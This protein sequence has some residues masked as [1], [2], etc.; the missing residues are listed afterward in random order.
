MKNTIFK[1]FIFSFFLCSHCFAGKY[2]AP[3]KYEDQE[4]ILVQ[5]S[6]IIVSHKTHEVSMYQTLEKITTGRANFYFTLTNNG[7][8]P[9]NFYFQNLKVSDQFGRPIEVVHKTELIQDKNSSKNWQ[10]FGS[11]IQSFADS[12]EAERAGKIDYHSH[13]DNHFGS[14]TNTIGSHGW[15]STAQNGYNSTVS[16]GS[17]HSEALRQQALR[18]AREDSAIRSSQIQDTFDTWEEK[19]NNFYFDSN[20]VFPKTSYSANF[21]I[22]IPRHIEKSLRYLLFTYEVG[23][24]THTFC[25]FVS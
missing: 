22:K 4:E 20:T 3:T 9:F 10:F 7:D 17:V 23:G 21:Q 12:L 18:Q 6:P 11:A 16:S 5:G 1:L 14:C 13:T 2:L 19:I 8:R 24:E 15:A 25:F